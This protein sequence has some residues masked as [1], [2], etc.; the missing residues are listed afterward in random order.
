MG[1]IAAC[2]MIGLAI[3][4]QIGLV[5]FNVFDIGAAPPRKLTTAYSPRW[6]IGVQAARNLIARINGVS[7]P[8]VIKFSITIRPGGTTR[9]PGRWE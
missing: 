3:P 1:G 6:N 2:E 7:P 9:A 8:A 5:G 4:D